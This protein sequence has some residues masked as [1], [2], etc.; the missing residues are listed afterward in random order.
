MRKQSVF[1]QLLATLIALLG[2]T[3]ISTGY[4][5]I[6]SL[7]SYAEDDAVVRQSELVRTL[8]LLYGGSGESEGG[9]VDD[10]I[11]SFPDSLGYRITIIDGD[12]TV[13]G[14]THEDPEGMDNHSD[15]PEVREALELGIGSATR[16]SDTQGGLPLIYTAFF[17]E[18]RNLVFRVARTVEGLRE[19][20][21]RSVSALTLF[22]LM[23]I[24]LSLL[25]SILA[26][27]RV[28]RLI[29]GIQNVAEHYAEGDFSEALSITGFREAEELSS[30]LNRMGRRLQ[31][32]ILALEFRQKE[33]Q[34][35]LEGMTAPVVLTDATL[36]V[37]EINPAARKL[38]ADEGD[39]VNRSLLQV[40]R[41]PELYD[42]A[43][44]LLESDGSG[45]AL[46]RLDRT[47]GPVYLQVNAS[48]IRREGEERSGCLLVM[49]DVTRIT[50]LE[51][52]RK[53]FVANVSHELRTPITSILG[54][55]ETLRN[56][57]ALD[58]DRQQSFLEI[59]HRQAVRLE[60]IIGD[61]MALS[62]LEE[63]AGILP[64]NP[65]RYSAFLKV[66]V[67]LWPSRLNP[68]TYP[69]V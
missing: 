24:I 38:A 6:Q 44:D 34:S 9:T 43:R 39:S 29:N 46:I 64:G 42:L 59:V 65:C 18:K 62:R 1:V 28:S 31:D 40:F 35:M 48:L 50:Q 69:S 53:D 5:G 8:A 11:G 36:G 45:E 26:A 27:R 14:D 60:H 54:F 47:G 37:R 2:L 25:V 32:T 17:D 57:G 15:R 52:M 41:S 51:M 10:F 21:D 33:L 49:N 7:R 68:G 13:L 19:G 56:A 4:F 63:G 61:L 55:V 58:A 3:I 30:S 23:L 66:P 12:G 22:A 20:L 16:S 67:I